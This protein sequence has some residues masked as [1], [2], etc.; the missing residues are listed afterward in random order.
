MADPEHDGGITYFSSRLGIP[1]EKLEDVAY[2]CK[3]NWIFKHKQKGPSQMVGLNLVEALLCGVCMFSPC[4]H[5][6][7]LGTLASSHRPKTSRSGDSK[8]PIVVNVRMNG[9]LSLYMLTL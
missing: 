3:L 2:Y 9:C 7:S 1:Q 6:F 5:W 8:L 4:L